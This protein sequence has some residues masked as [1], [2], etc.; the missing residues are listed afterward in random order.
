MRFH[1]SARR[2]VVSFD[3]GETV[4]MY[5]C[6]LT[7]YDA[8]HVG[9]AATYVTFDLLKRRL[10]DAGHQV[11]CV[12]NITDVD[13]D[14]L[15]RA[16]RLGVHY[17]DLA[18]AQLRRFHDDLEALA[19]TPMS[20][21]PRATGV[22]PDIRGFIHQVLESGHAYRSGGA[23]YFD[24]STFSGFGELSGYDEAEMVLLAGQ[25][26]GRPDDPARRQPLDFVLWQPSA[27][28][29]PAWDSPWGPGRPGWHI[30]CSALALRELG[31]T[32]DIH[33]GGRDLLFPHHECERAQSESVTG[34]PF[35]RYWMHQ[36]LVGLDGVKMSKSL[37]NLVFVADLTA[38]HEPRA[39]RLAVL[40][41]H[42]RLD[43]EWRDELVSAAARRLAVW[44]AA[45]RTGRGAS[46]VL[47]DV[48][49][50]LDDDLDAPAALAVVDAAA[51][52]GFDIDSAA[53]LLGVALA[54]SDL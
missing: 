30:Q 35:V 31:E 53:A 14:L 28:D 7:P 51:A 29:E 47:D 32:I 34:Q 45:S 54:P 9:H 13:D 6:G 3:L 43:W 52:A 17:L 49:A 15:E 40:G 16:R 27:P 38:A 50:A 39:V 11:R 44:D 37:G 24:V 22:V 25:R 5:V 1:D 4:T 48:R 12:R 26:G 10:L 20:V 41:Q 21:E 36:G 42:Y 33:G 19:V 23:V 46:G 18:T 2:E 8:T